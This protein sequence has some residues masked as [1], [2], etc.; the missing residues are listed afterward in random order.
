MSC[1]IA[2][3]LDNVP[4]FM[5]SVVGFAVGYLWGNGTATALTENEMFERLVAIRAK[6]IDEKVA[7]GALNAA[8]DYADD[9]R[10]KGIQKGETST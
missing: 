2:A 3:I 6:R 9:Q 5:L 4:W 1:Q 7:R 8:L 10:L